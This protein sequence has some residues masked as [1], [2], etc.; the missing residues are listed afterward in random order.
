MWLLR[1]NLVLHTNPHVGQGCVG[2]VGAV[3]ARSCR[4]LR[5]SA[6]CRDDLASRWETPVWQ[7]ERQVTRSAAVLA[8]LEGGIL[9]SFSNTFMWSLYR[10]RCPPAALWPDW[11]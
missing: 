4:S 2:P 5:F 8:R 1:P 6:R 10:F 3:A 9:Q 11:S 7:E